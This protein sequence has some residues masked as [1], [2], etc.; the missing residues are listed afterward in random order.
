[1]W[2]LRLESEALESEQ[3][4]RGLKNNKKIII[5]KDLFLHRR[6]WGGGWGCASVCFSRQMVL[7]VTEASF[8][9]DQREGQNNCRR[10]RIDGGVGGGKVSY[11]VV[12]K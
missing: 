10:L 8:Q 5:K 6:A 4:K 3:T 11:S 1:M 2:L 7:K 12:G 9:K